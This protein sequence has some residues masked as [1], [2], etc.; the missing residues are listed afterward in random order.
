MTTAAIDTMIKMV[1]S[2]PEPTQNQVVE[3]LRE[4]LA[5]LMDEYQWDMSF[6]MTEN[7]LKKAAKRA[8]QEIAL[9]KANPLEF[10]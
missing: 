2:L 4:Y 9:G 7:Q 6:K 10:D 1:E 3:H 5:D 8:R